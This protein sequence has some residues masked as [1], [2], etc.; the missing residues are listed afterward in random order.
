MPVFI[1]RFNWLFAFVFTPVHIGIVHKAGNKVSKGLFFSLGVLCLVNLLCIS[2]DK[3]MDVIS[4]W[5]CLLNEWSV[6]QGTKDQFWLFSGAWRWDQSL[7][8]SRIKRARKCRQK[9]QG[10]LSTI[11]QGV[12]GSFY[13]F[14]NGIVITQI[15]FEN[16]HWLFLQT[17][18][19]LIFSV[20]G[21]QRANDAE[22]QGH[23]TT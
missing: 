1:K 9:K 12:K 8:S 3:L 19:Q 13:C 4:L 16:I 10:L 22:S 2:L 18:Y 14:L 7:G 20:V 23:T 21:N 17:S 5:S 11:R 6:L 15:L